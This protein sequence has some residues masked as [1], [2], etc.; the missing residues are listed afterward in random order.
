MA[1]GEGS[2]PELINDDADGRKAEEE[3]AGG[4]VCETMA[5]TAFAGAAAGEKKPPGPEHRMTKREIR[6][7]LAYKPM[8]FV[9]TVYEALKRS[10]P[11]LKPSPEEEM[12]EPK[13]HLYSIARLFYEH[14][15][16]YPKLQERVR[17]ELQTKGYVEVDDKW[18]QGRAEMQV[19]R[20]KT[21][22]EI[23]E[24]FL[25]YPQTDDEDEDEDD[26]SDSDYSDEDY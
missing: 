2:R 10:N 15:E 8:A 25:K 17:R 4:A 9:P 13:C 24:L 19:L 23:D 22:K 6:C 16:N 18:V 11:E 7:I 1:C 20:E 26:D 12:D 14:E 21:Q 3:A 5:A